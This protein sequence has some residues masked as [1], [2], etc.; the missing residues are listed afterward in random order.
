MKNLPEIF[1][2]CKNIVFDDN[3]TQ[4]K[5]WKANGEKRVLI[6]IIP[7]YFPREIIHAANGFAVGIIG[8]ELKLPFQSEQTGF[9]KH[10]CSFLEGLF[11][12]VK[13]QDYEAFDG[14][15]L[16]S[17]CS[18]LAVS[19]EIVN[20]KQN[21]KFIKYINFPQY[22]QTIISNI[23]NHNLVTEVLS[24]LY[25]INGIEVTAPSL[26]NS[27]QLFKDNLRLTEKIYDLSVK[28]LS[29]ISQEDLYYTVLAG[30]L[31]PVEEHNQILENIIELLGVVDEEESH[32]LFRVYSGVYC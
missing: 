4:A 18:T 8:K 1:E 23:L 15:I 13:S 29:L 31:L 20:I 10:S 25:R 21:G 24:E 28:K 32:N 7:N 5:K 19:S 3:Y 30:L 9:E 22:F 16:P 17:Q 11:D 27:I 2:E 12:M 26:V 14:F 6:G